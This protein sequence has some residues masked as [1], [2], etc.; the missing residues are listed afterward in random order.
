MVLGNTGNTHLFFLASVFGELETSWCLLIIPAWEKLWQKDFW[1][2]S[3]GLN[4]K[5]L[6]QKGKISVALLVSWCVA[7]RSRQLLSSPGYP[8]LVGFDA[9]R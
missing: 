5:T 2:F 1:E 8:V 7:G 9:P 3:S 6:N 4:S